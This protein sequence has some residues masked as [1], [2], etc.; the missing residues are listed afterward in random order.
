[1]GGRV[2][3]SASAAGGGGGGGG[4]GVGCGG[5]ELG[6]A[7]SACASPILNRRCVR[8]A[9][10]D[11]R[12]LGRDGQGAGP[13]GR[14]LAGGGVA[15]SQRSHRSVEPTED[16]ERAREPR[17]ARSSQGREGAR[18][19]GWEGGEEKN[20][21]EIKRARHSPGGGGGERSA[22]VRQ[23]LC[24]PHTADRPLTSAEPRAGPPG[25]GGAG[26]GE[27]R[28]PGPASAGGGGARTARPAHPRH[29]P[30]CPGRGSPGGSCADPGEGGAW[31]R[32]RAAAGPRPELSPRGPSCQWERRAGRPSGGPPGQRPAPPHS[33]SGFLSILAPAARLLGCS[34]AAG[35]VAAEAE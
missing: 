35:A 12:A 11:P 13:G 28:A 4:G 19:R 22:R 30:F 3:P 25:R 7:A 9:F 21:G 6:G 8:G 23:R 5:S 18:D 14:S 29:H 24:A 34:P 15:V 2:G 33:L 27:A 1:M 16:E 32:A 26:A 17:A 20:E 31:A 10:A